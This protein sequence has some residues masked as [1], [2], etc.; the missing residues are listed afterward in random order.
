MGPLAGVKVLEFEAIGPVPFCGMMLADMGADVLLVD[1][2]ADAGLGLER[3]RWFD[4]MLRGR[5]SVTLDLK[6]PGGVAAA[7]TL[8]RN[9]DV[10]LEGFR[11][12]V[13]ERLGIGP[14]AMLAANP[15]LVYGAHDRL[16]PGRSARAARRTRHQLHRHVR[17][18]ARDRTRR[19][20]PRASAQPGRR[21]RRRR[22]AAR[23]RRRVRADRSATLGQ[24]TGR[25]RRDGGGRV[26]AV[27]DVLGHA[28]WRP[29]ER[30][31]RRQRAGHRRAVV[32]RVRNGRPP[33]MSPSAPS[34]PS[35]TRN[36]CSAWG[37]RARRFR[38]STIARAGPSCGGA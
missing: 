11:P 23:V 37:W 16:G 34:S 9:A 35:S 27:H 8:A 24:G 28:R 29:V 20:R 2:P 15:A 31:A 10:V 32:R 5:R 13:M 1:R 3:E 18:A 17:R 33:A 21:L 14:D 12:G 30:R 7:L 26:A 19:R 4:T 25:R 22:H 6:S 36:C 38:R